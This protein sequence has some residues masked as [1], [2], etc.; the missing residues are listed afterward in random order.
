MLFHSSIRKELAHS[1]AATLLVLFTIVVTIMLIRTLGLA[2]SGSVDPKEVMLV[3]GYTVL[4][5]LHIILTM[6][7]FISVVSVLSRMHS[8]S[9]MIIWMASGRGLV[10]M[11]GP[12]VR[13]A[14][15][16]LA[17][18]C[19]LVLIAWPWACLLYTSRCG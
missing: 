9:E 19:V 2:T 4:G 6:A 5:R 12:I 13:F 10:G 11:F 8:A 14:W 17:G 7:L 1:F 18:M 16:V 15:P 3:L